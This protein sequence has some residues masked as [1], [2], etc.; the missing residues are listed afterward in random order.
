MGRFLT[1]AAFAIALGG[2]ALSPSVGQNA[3]QQTPMIGMME[4][5][6]PMVGIMGQSMMGPG[7]SGQGMMAGRQARMA[8]LVDGA[9]QGMRQALTD[10]MQKGDATTRMDARIKSMEVMAESMKALKPATETLYAVLT[11]EQR[12]LADQL[13]GVAC[14]AM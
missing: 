8:A 11:D 12:K 4:G 9:M 5:G 1:T 6:C 2:V 14:G 13:I 3:D 10:A 7:M